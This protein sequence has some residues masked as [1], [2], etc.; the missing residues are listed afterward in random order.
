[1]KAKGDGTALGTRDVVRWVLVIALAVG[2]F[3]QVA[4]ATREFSAGDQAASFYLVNLTIDFLPALIYAAAVGLAIT[5]RGGAVAW[6]ILLICGLALT[7]VALFYAATSGFGGLM[8]GPPCL[9]ALCLVQLLTSS[10]SRIA[11]VR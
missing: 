9:V 11:E 1:M 6:G 4:L 3:V 5:R 7:A 8:L 2:V 10:R